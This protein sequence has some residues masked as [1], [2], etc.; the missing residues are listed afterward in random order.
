[1]VLDFLV[2]TG[3]IQFRI[4]VATGEGCSCAGYFGCRHQWWGVVCE[5]EQRFLFTG[6]L[7]PASGDCSVA[8]NC[9]KVPVLE[10]FGAIFLFHTVQNPMPFWQPWKSLEISLASQAKALS[11]SKRGC[12]SKA[13]FACRDGNEGSNVAICFMPV[14]PWKMY[15]IHLSQSHLSNQAVCHY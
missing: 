9:S 8:N 1:M 4:R 13:N 14:S 15:L 7:M 5:A 12:A 3:F 10:S 11:G 2:H 6:V